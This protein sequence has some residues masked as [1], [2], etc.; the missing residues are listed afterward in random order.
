MNKGLLNKFIDQKDNRHFYYSVYDPCHQTVVE[1][2]FL[3]D[4]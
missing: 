2:T 1:S 3:T 4:K